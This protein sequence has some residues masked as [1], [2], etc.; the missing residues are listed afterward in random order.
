MGAVYEAVHRDLK[1]RVAIKVLSTAIAGEEVRQRFLREGE[2]ASRIQH[3]NVVDVTDVG[4]EGYLNYL[5]MELLEGEDLAHRLLRQRVMS[6]LEI[7]DLLLPVC[8]GLAVAHDEGV[9]H[10]DLKPEN[11]FLVRQRHG[12]VEPKVLDFGISKLTGRDAVAM[13]GTLATFGTPYYMPPEQVRGARQ[14]D[15]RSDVYA[16]GVVLYECLTGRRPFEGDNIYSML[17]AIGA[18]EYPPPRTVKPG[19]PTE[20]EAVIVRAM[21]LEPANRFPT[22]RHL[23]S[24]LLAFASDKARVV[25]G[26]TFA[27]GE[28]PPPAVAPAA[29]APPVTGGMAW[30]ATAT[31]LPGQ[32]PLASQSWPTTKG[33]T[34]GSATGHQLDTTPPRR[35]RLGTVVGGVVAA[36]ALLLVGAK[37]LRPAAPPVAAPPPVAVV[38]EPAAPA[39]PSPRKTYRVEVDADPAAATLELD[40]VAT[41]ARTLRRDFSVDGREHQLVGRAPGYRDAVVTFIDSPPDRRLSLDPVPAPA[42]AAASAPEAHAR[43]HHHPKAASPAPAAK[44]AAPAAAPEK[45]AS[46]SGVPVID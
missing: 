21:Q 37:L 22:V 26:E 28:G 20:V 10:R 33:T 41:G 4:T 40:G 27:T 31:P 3:P 18:G 5:V 6:P 1:K 9:V 32:G 36:A 17:H 46:K 44:P 25:W 13:T 29:S 12:G 42:K 19:L 7:A 24:A 23:A 43:A 38:A 15:Q 2:A 34:L 35:S 45:P 14:A 16:L 11:I 8:A 39:P 30:A